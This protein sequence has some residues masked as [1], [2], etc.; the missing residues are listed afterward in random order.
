MKGII[1]AAFAGLFTFLSAF[2]ASAQDGSTAVRPPFRLNQ[3]VAQTGRTFPC[4][5]TGSADTLQTCGLASYFS[6]S[7]AVLGVDLAAFFSQP[8]AG[9]PAGTQV[10]CLGLDS[11]NHLVTASGACGSGSGSGQVVSGAAGQLAY[12]PSSTASV[13]GNANATISNGDL[14]LGVANTTIGRVKVNG[15]TSGVVT[16]QPQAAAGTWTLTLPATGGT[17]GYSLTTDGSGNTSWTNIA[18]SSGV[19][20]VAT[21]LSLTV[22]TAQASCLQL[23][24]QQSV[25]A[26]STATSA[27]YNAVCLPTP[28]AGGHAV[29][30]NRSANPIQACPVTGAQINNLTV[31]TGC[32][33][34][35]AGSTAPFWT[36][37][38]TEYDTP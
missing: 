30:I 13:S 36:P 17:N 12:Y 10:S 22:G 6:F 31:T 8:L 28:V 37:T 16:I 19:D 38:T 1:A 3:I 7:G 32:K 27:P 33:L 23:T 9:L 34:V 4:N 20:T 25:V 11:G 26:T 5:P 21:G 2:P 18:A 35:L 29:V 15:N 24:S 14:S